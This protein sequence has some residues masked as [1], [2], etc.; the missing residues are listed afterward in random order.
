MKTSATTAVLFCAIALITAHPIIPEVAFEESLDQVVAEDSTQEG[1]HTQEANIPKQQPTVV[2]GFTFTSP[3]PTGDIENDGLDYLA[4]VAMACDLDDDDMLDGSEMLYCFTGLKQMYGERHTDDY[5]LL[6]FKGIVRVLVLFVKKMVEAMEAAKTSKFTFETNKVSPLSFSSLRS[7]W[8][9]M[10]TSH[11]EWVHESDEEHLRFFELLKATGKVTSGLEAQD[12]EATDAVQF[13]QEFTQDRLEFESVQTKDDLTKLANKKRVFG[14]V[15][16][17]MWAHKNGLNVPEI[18]A[19]IHRLLPTDE[20]RVDWSIN[21]LLEGYKTGDAFKVDNKLDVAQT[22]AAEGRRI[23]YE[24]HKIHNKLQKD[25]SNLMEMTESMIKKKTMAPVDPTV[26]S[27]VHDVLSTLDENLSDMNKQTDSI[28]RRLDE[29]TSQFIPSAKPKAFLAQK[30]ACRDKPFELAGGHNCTWFAKLPSTRCQEYEGPQWISN[31]IYA[32]DACC[33]CGGGDREGTN[34]TPILAEEARAKGALAHAKGALAHAK[35]AQSKT[36]KFLKYAVQAAR[37]TKECEIGK[38]IDTLGQCRAVMESYGKKVEFYDMT[39]SDSTGNFP[40]G[41]ST[42]TE[43]G[44]F[45]FN[46]A[47]SGGQSFTVSPVCMVDGTLVNGCPEMLEEEMAL[48]NRLNIQA[49]IAQ[50]SHELGRTQR[51]V[52]SMYDVTSMLKNLHEIVNKYKNIVV[53]LRKAS[54]AAATMVGTIPVLGKVV[55]LV[56]TMA[57]FKEVFV[58]ILEKVL[59]GL[60]KLENPVGKIQKGVDSSKKAVDILKAK[61]T[62]FYEIMDAVYKCKEC[63]HRE[64]AQQGIAKFNQVV[65]AGHSAMKD[66]H[67]VLKPIND[68]PMAVWKWIKGHVSSL[69]RIVSKITDL[70]QPIAEFLDA[71]ANQVTKALAELKC[72]LSTPFQVTLNAATAIADV[73]LC[74]LWGLLNGLSDWLA[75]QLTSKIS[76]LLKAVTPRVKFQL[77]GWSMNA[78]LKMHIEHSDCG[79]KKPMDIDSDFS[80]PAISFDTHA[81]FSMDSLPGDLSSVSDG[82]KDSILGTCRDATKS[83]EA[84]FDTCKCKLPFIGPLINEVN[85]A[86]DKT[87]TTIAHEG[88]NVVSSVVSSLGFSIRL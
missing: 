1:G 60:S 62:M 78:K 86:I 79:V 38:P 30:A 81:I 52:D 7:S 32:G 58:E 13:T 20:D 87:L 61:T 11:P 51:G 66:C 73:A 83:L 80:F 19:T 75:N 18:V 77:G 85:G 49:D 37:N 71:V 76:Q 17:L 54:D 16:L 44:N 31:G 29:E 69:K 26:A 39:K 88:T 8:T 70:V 36:T 68:G 41:C 64:A 82:I 33:A 47:A 35:G 5:K 42:D 34:E 74:P 28:S 57:R 46:G 27:E 59:R 55:N 4:A 65:F 63:A 6:T 10:S 9:D 43:N 25:L 72:C 22:Q 15:E 14:H 2:D 56:K 24:N 12:E 67:S 45:F 21:L 48:R 40:P 84:V 53:K 23:A 50:C 3:Q